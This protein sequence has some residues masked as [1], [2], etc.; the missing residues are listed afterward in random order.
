MWINRIWFLAYIDCTVSS[1][2]ILDR[3][4]CIC[5]WLYILI[6]GDCGLVKVCVFAVDFVRCGFVGIGCA[7]C[8]LYN[9]IFGHCALVKPYYVCYWLC[10]FILGHY[11]LAEFGG[12]PF[13][14][15]F[16]TWLPLANW[17]CLCLLLCVDCIVSYF[18]II[19]KLDLFVLAFVCLLYSFILC[20]HLQTGFVCACFCVFAIVCLPLPVQ[21][22][23]WSSLAN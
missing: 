1:L 14:V 8:W 6:L 17:V 5:C 18:V 15:Q 9:F 7:C 23:T 10:S 16:H 21:F 20:H 3:L 13:T 11:E 12:L 2:V 19:C 4:G 22:H